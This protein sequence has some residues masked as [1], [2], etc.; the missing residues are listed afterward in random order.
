M[1]IE[2]LKYV[3]EVAR[4]RSISAAAKKLFVGQSTLS[5]I[6]QQVETELQC[7]LFQR[8]S[9]GIV[10]TELGEEGVRRIERT[11]EE[12][13][14]LMALKS[15]RLEQKRSIHLCAYPCL[16]GTLNKLLMPLVEI[17]EYHDMVLAIHETPENKILARILDGTA[18]LAVGLC[19]AEGL[20]DVRETVKKAGF[21]VDELARDRSCLCVSK[22]LYE[23]GELPPTEACRLAAA[24]CCMET[25]G[26]RKLGEISQDI[27]VLPGMEQVLQAVAS[28]DFIA[29]I[30][31]IP[32]QKNALVRDGSVV[33]CSAYEQ[34][35][36]LVNYLIYPEERLS[37][38]E[39]AAI[40]RIREWFAHS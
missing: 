32:L 38:L 2:H 24:Q 33:V 27:T 34:E 3:L 30:P 40:G 10:L 11:L 5:S 9:K 1:K 16:C 22:R 6:I 21:T 12:Y 31:G 13:S 37:M 36:E 19:A 20:D 15:A 7:S 35:K 28:H 8:T 14:S 17:D 29:V 39:V 26:Y 23:S 25:H 18:T 4:C